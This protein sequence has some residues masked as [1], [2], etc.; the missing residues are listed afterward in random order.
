MSTKIFE[1]QDGSHSLISPQFG[2]AYHSRHGAI[3]ESMHVFIGHALEYAAYRKKQVN[4]FEM[5]FGTGLNAWLSLLFAQQHNL[6]IHYQTIEQ[7]PVDSET[8]NKLNYHKANIP[9]L[10]KLENNKSQFL[11]LHNSSW[12]EKETIT[13][14]FFLSKHKID[15]NNF[16]LKEKVDIIYYDA[17]A[18]EAQPELWTQAIFEKM[19]AM[20][21][22]QG[23]LTTYCAKGYVRRNL[24]AAG[25]TV[26]RLEGPPGKREM[27]RAQKF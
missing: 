1:T 7:F 11:K 17:F 16:Q 20:L 5:G 4:I 25:F 14:N 3:Q 13:P 23:I 26:E 9:E 6:P 19:K 2:E 21:C 10:G 18:P 27:L 24:K 8:V 15:L 22:E 12:G